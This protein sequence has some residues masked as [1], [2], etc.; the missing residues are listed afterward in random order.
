[1]RKTHCERVNIQQ[2]VF[3]TKDDCE[4]YMDWDGTTS[5]HALEWYREYNKK[6]HERMKCVHNY[7]TRQ[8]TDRRE[9]LAGDNHG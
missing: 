9:R 2:T 8:R 5:D 3:C 1:M 6:H 7:A 4:F